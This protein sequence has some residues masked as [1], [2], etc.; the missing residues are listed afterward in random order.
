MSKFA[1]GI[2]VYLPWFLIWVALELTAVWWKQCPWPTLSR[3]AWDAED[4]WTWLQLVFFAGLAILLV[5]IAF[6]WPK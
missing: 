2:A 5:H 3:T 1:W 4:K 6:R